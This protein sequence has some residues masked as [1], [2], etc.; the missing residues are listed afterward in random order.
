M[1]RFRFGY[2]IRTEFRDRAVAIYFLSAPFQKALLFC[3]AGFWKLQQP[4]ETH[5]IKIKKLFILPLI[6]LYKEENLRFVV[7]V[8]DNPITRKHC[9][10][11]T[12][13]NDIKEIVVKHFEERVVFD[14]AKRS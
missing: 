13:I 1:V 11:C 4:L 9:V 2:G 5:R 10:V 14:S 6:Y 3:F 8:V 12:N 7:L